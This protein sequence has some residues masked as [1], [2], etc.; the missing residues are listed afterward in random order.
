MWNMGNWNKSN[1]LEEITFELVGLACF[2][3]VMVCRLS[4]ESGLDFINRWMT[5]LKFKTGKSVRA[6][7]PEHTETK[8]D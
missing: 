8:C 6:H 4:H 1:N 7:G 2:L 5:V 3:S